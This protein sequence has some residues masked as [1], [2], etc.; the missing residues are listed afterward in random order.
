MRVIK[1]TCCLGIRF[2]FWFITSVANFMNKAVYFILVLFIV[3]SCQQ[4][5]S[6]EEISEEITTLLA[7]AE[8][9]STL[10]KAYKSND[11]KPVWVK[12][13]GL[14]NAGEEFLAGLEEV[15]FDGLVKEDYWSEEQTALL[16]E[17]Q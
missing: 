16:E 12:S 17:V 9:D 6:P 4:K 10:S 3:F 13:N 2:A 11:Y 1:I 15:V 8:M 7:V 14:K 5:P